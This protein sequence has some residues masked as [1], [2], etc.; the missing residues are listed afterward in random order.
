MKKR[1]IVILVLLLVFIPTF[2]Y[3]AQNRVVPKD[4][5]I[6]NCSLPNSKFLEWK[7][8]DIHYVEYGEKGKEQ[9]LTLHGFGGSLHNFKA[10]NNLL[11]NDY[12][13]LALDLPGFALSDAP[14]M[15]IFGEGNFMEVYRQFLDFII[16]E[17]E[18]NDFHL[19]GNS[20]GGWISWETA[21]VYPDKIKSL[22]LSASAGYE[23]EKVAKIAT[24]WLSSKKVRKFINRGFPMPLL[25][26]NVHN[27]IFY[28]KN[29]ISNDEIKINYFLFNKEGSIDWMMDLAGSGTPAD[30]S[31][32]LSI[33]IP[34]LIIWG[35]HDK[36]VPVEHA[37]KFYR[38]LPNSQKIIYENCGHVPQIEFAERF[39][40]DLIEFYKGLKIN[41][42]DTLIEVK[43]EALE[44][45]LN[46]L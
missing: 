8:M 16:T 39:R 32:I 18:L 28:D 19:I 10:L 38:D 22:T 37:D 17:F 14:D 26:A 6:E 43:N 5:A 40:D 9:I 1:F 29:K 27:K 36:I 42:K 45:N 30:T 23:M 34:T 13:V 35:K 46:V 2:I 7:G 21:S 12:Y 44:N 31:K 15:A 33:E 25:K 11:S 20:M 41:K 24:G 3:L 4:I